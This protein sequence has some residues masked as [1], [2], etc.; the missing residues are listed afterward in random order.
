MPYIVDEDREKFENLQEIADKISCAGDL[1][2]VVTVLCQKYLVN[3]GIRYQYMN[4]VI[5]ALEGCK[6]ELYRRIVGRYEDEKILDN[7][8]VME[9]G[10]G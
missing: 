10:L 2:Y 5:G 9:D 3:N 4:D 8:D 6:L 1:N 7:G